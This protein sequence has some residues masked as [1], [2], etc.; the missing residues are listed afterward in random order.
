MDSLITIAWEHEITEPQRSKEYYKAIQE[1]LIDDCIVIP[2]SDLNVQSVSR[3]D[4]HGLRANPA[5]S[6][7]LIYNLERKND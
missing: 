7:L 3:S 1:K 4:I 2:A 6:T 5:Y